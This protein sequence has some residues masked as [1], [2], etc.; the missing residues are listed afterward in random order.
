MFLAPKI[1]YC[2]TKNKNGVI[3]EHKTFEG[4]INVSD[5]LDRNEY[6]RM[7]EGDILIAK[8]PLNWKKSFSYGVVYPHKIRNCKECT[9]HI[10]C[11]DCDKLI[12][13][14]KDFSANLNDIKRQPPT[15]FGHTLPK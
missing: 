7:F 8:V 3:D 11:D 2:L 15:D 4:F 5:N 6:F 9:K 13:Q 1:K 12:N 14:N 10:L